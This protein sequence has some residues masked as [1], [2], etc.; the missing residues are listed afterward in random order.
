MPSIVGARG[1]R[2]S[3]AKRVKKNRRSKNIS[4]W[5]THL[6]FNSYSEYLNSE[7]WQF[8]RKQKLAKNRQCECCGYEATDVHHYRY[9]LHTMAGKDTS[10]LVSLCRTCHT[11]VEFDGGE[12]LPLWKCQ[13][14]LIE[15]LQE[16]G[17][18][19]TASLLV[20]KMKK[21]SRD[22]LSRHK[23]SRNGLE[24]MSRPKAVAKRKLS[25]C[26]KCSKSEA[27]LVSGMCKQCVE[28]SG[29]YIPRPQYS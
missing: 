24:K 15:M 1:V 3:S 13:Q 6:G 27:F 11:A 21:R 10:S 19:S 16:H 14:K 23:V 4:K 18:E 8:I 17:N 2:I 5:R 20:G 22:S 26:S 12:K 7:L 25:Q 29:V 9:D 28:S